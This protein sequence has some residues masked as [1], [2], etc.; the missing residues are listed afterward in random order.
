MDDNQR[1]DAGMTQRRK[2]LGNEWVDKSIANRNAFNT[3]FQ[4]LI[5]RY[6]WGDIWTPGRISITVRA[7]CS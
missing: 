1:R 6:A 2:V 5:T 4:E 7:A 3:E